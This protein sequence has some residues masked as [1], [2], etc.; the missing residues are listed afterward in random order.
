VASA[1]SIFD[2]SSVRGTRT[3]KLFA[4]ETTM[5]RFPPAI[6][7]GIISRAASIEARRPAWVRCG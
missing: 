3:F 5:A 4:F 7:F 6:S 1:A 2:S